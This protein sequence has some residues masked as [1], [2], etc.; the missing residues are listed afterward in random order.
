MAKKVLTKKDKTVKIVN[1]MQGRKTPAARAD[2]LNELQEKVGI[3]ANCAAT[4]YQN[5]KLGRWS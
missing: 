2:I 1:R 3:S 4:Y 5:V